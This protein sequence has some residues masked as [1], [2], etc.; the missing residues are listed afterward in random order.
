MSFEENLHEAIKIMGIT[1]KELSA[2]TGIKEDTISSYLKTNGAMPT[3]EKAVKLADALNTSVEFLVT[4]F[5]KKSQISIYEMHK[6]SKYSKYM[7]ALDKLPN[8]S[9]DPILKM[10]SDMS[11]K[12]SKS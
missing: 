12:Y 5:E 10:I 7:D 11:R 4:G 6:N 1:T 2:K 9:R 8:E 3:A